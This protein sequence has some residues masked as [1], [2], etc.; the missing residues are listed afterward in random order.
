MVGDD[1]GLLRGICRFPSQRS[2]K[3]RHR[4][5]WRGMR[6]VIHKF[7]PLLNPMVGGIY[8]GPPGWKL[9]VVLPVA[10]E[11]LPKPLDRL[12][13]LEDLRNRLKQIGLGQTH[14]QMSALVSQVETIGGQKI[15]KLIIN[16]LALIPESRIAAIC[17]QLGCEA[18]AAAIEVVQKV[19]SSPPTILVFDRSD[20]R[21]LRPLL[22]AV[23]SRCQL[24]ALTTRYPAAHPAILAR[25]ASGCRA[26]DPI[27]EGILSIDLLTCLLLGKAMLEQ[28]RPSHRPVQIFVT[29]QVPRVIWTA[30]GLPI[31]EVFRQAGIDAGAMQCIANGLL[32]GKELDLS[33]A[34]MEM[35]IETLALRPYPRT[36]VAVDCIR[37]GWCVQSCPTALNP[38]A[39]YAA[40]CMHEGVALADPHD[41]LACIDCGLCSYICPSRL[42]LSTSIQE[43]RNRIEFN[44]VA[45]VGGSSL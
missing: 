27:E 17:A 8:F 40:Q 23:R 5:K 45:A 14:P 33:S 4:I 13:N 20:R 21:D 31:R 42:P 2:P 10:M 38:A 22:R 41:S 29:G 15:K 25:I 19:F 37:C 24:M 6:S 1:S 39:L 11:A 16:G 7:S 36:E 34:S 28:V 9:P 30:I 35:D 26:V 12:G 3:V 43:M 44:L 32:A 18:I